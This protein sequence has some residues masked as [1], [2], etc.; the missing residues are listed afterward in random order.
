MWKLTRVVSCIVCRNWPAVLCI[1]H[2]SWCNRL[3]TCTIKIDRMGKFTGGTN[4]NSNTSS[5]FACNA[6]VARVRSRASCR[7]LSGRCAGLRQWPIV[8]CLITYVHRGSS[9]LHCTYVRTAQLWLRGVAFGP[10]PAGMARPLPQRCRACM[11]VRTYI[12]TLHYVL[13][14]RCI[15]EVPSDMQTRLVDV[16]VHVYAQICLRLAESDV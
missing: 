11:Y 1:P 13:D 2:R 16:Q 10:G 14:P 7:W 3:C 8:A 15:T 9:A 6:S 5:R 12:R 4:A